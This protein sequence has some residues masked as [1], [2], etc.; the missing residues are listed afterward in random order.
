M[1]SG[2]AISFSGQRKE[3]L[4]AAEIAKS[5]G[6]VAIAIISLRDSGLRKLAAHTLNTVSDEQRC[7][8]FSISSRTGQLCVIALL[9]MGLLQLNESEGMKMIEQSRKLV[10]K[11][12]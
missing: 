8:S 11:L 4:L 3:M 6:A 2:R 9:F 1:P 7:R 5:R 12:S 10:D